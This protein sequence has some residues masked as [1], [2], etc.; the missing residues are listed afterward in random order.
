M[1]LNAIK[2]TPVDAKPLVI[3]IEFEIS[4]E[5]IIAEHVAKMILG[6]YANVKR[7]IRQL[8][9]ST[10]IPLED[11]VTIAISKLNSKG[12][13]K[14]EIQKRDG[15]VFQMI[16][17]LSF[18]IESIG[19]NMYCQYPHDAPAQQGIDGIAIY[20]DSKNDIKKI[21]ITEDK[22]TK[23]PRNVIQKQI[24]PEFKAF[25]EG[26]FNNKIIS[27]I[28]ALI[29]NLED[30]EVLQ[31]IQNDILKKEIRSYRAVT[32]REDIHNG[33]TGKETLFKDYDDVVKGN[34][35]QRRLA[36]T[37]LI[38]GDIRIWMEKFT[39]LIIGHLEKMK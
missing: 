23:A 17:W 30:G 36:S 1:S 14:I 33:I 15:W 32:N 31:N 21:I 34:D 9:T 38:S 20:L 24:W 19:Q 12:K 25:D 29:E 3:D 4:D 11:D 39:Q 27:R 37:I 26:T 5:D 28:S 22:F 18:Q 13:N 2:H 7:V 6:Y 10:F 35:H 16:S 8:P